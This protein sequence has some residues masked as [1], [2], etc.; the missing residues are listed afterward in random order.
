MWYS[1]SIICEEMVMEPFNWNSINVQELED[2][3]SVKNRLSRIHSQVTKAEQVNKL[4]SPGFDPGPTQS[5]TICVMTGLG[6]SIK[7]ISDILLIEEKMLKLFYKRELEG[8]A[9]Y[10]NLAVSKKALEMALSGNHPEMTKFWLKT[11]AGWRE[12][13]NVEVTGKDGGAIEINSAKA[14]LLAGL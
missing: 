11:Q 13:S 9:P 14:T 2:D 6:M 3:A 12:T 8:A 1:A 10:V 7:Q 4:N 5:K